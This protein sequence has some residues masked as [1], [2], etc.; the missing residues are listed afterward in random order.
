MM[1]TCIAYNALFNF[2]RVNQISE[3]ENTCSLCFRVSQKLI[4]ANTDALLRAWAFM[5]EEQIV[6]NE[7]LM[8]TTIAAR[9]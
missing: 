2:T 9:T 7:T 3:L 1:E 8:N 4:M 6:D 5:A